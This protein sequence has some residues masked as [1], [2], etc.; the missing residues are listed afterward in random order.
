MNEDP[1]VAAQAS[2]AEII[3]Q[4]T[5]ICNVGSEHLERSYTPSHQPQPFSSTQLK[6]QTLFIESE[7]YLLLVGR[8]GNGFQVTNDS[9]TN[10]Y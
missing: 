8:P 5:T 2:V 6:R 9:L 1:S 10:I 7:K 4:S 3:L